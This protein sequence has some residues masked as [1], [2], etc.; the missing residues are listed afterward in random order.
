MYIF[1]YII[2]Y[3]ILVSADVD[4]TIVSSEEKLDTQQGVIRKFDE[5]MPRRFLDDLNDYEFHISHL[6]DVELDGGKGQCK[7]TFADKVKRYKKMLANDA[8][9]IQFVSADEIPVDEKDLIP[10]KCEPTVNA[11]IV[12]ANTTLA[13][14]I[15][16]KTIESD[17]VKLKLDVT[18][19]DNLEIVNAATTPK[20]KHKKKKDVKGRRASEY[21]FSSVEYYDEVPD[22]ADTICPDVVDIVKLQIDPLKPYDVE[23]ELMLEWHSLT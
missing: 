10:E 7:E 3:L 22:F 23:C 21:L 20:V 13:T 1:V 15:D 9:R 19:K 16:N 11:T 5:S 4:K 17:E 6:K 14:V 18:T 2:T 8:S 12:N